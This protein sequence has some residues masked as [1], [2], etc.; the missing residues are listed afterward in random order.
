MHDS[1]FRKTP[2]HDPHEPPVPVL[3]DLALARYKY[4]QAEKARFGGPGED[5]AADLDED[6]LA[7]KRAY[8]WAL[9]KAFEKG[10]GEI[11]FF[12]RSTASILPAGGVAR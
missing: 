7:E 5:A 1:M 9:R 2:A 12:V 3:A 11:V 10:K 6:G 8:Y 4:V